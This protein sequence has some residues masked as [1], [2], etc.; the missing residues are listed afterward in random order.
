MYCAKIAES[1]SDHAQRNAIGANN[2]SSNAYLRT[3][4]RVLCS[5]T[6]D[7]LGIVIVEQLLVQTHVLLLSEDGIVVLEAVL[8]QK[9]GVTLQDC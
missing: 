2:Y 1:T 9:R 5:T 8:L 4:S 6:G 3:T 7:Q